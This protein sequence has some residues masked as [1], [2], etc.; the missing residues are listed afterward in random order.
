MI[1][2]EDNWPMI[3]PLPNAGHCCNSETWKFGVSGEIERF[4]SLCGSAVWGLGGDKCWNTDM[5][6]GFVKNW[7][8][9]ILHKSFQQRHW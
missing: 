3:V 5:V 9:V 4:S 7:C 6:I 8:V 2:H 1:I